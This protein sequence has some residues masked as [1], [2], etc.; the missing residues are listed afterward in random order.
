MT[1]DN[2][3][4]MA[5]A[6]RYTED[7]RQQIEDARRTYKPG[8]ISEKTGL[9]KQNDGTWAPPKVGATGGQKAPGTTAGKSRY[10]GIKRLSDLP[11]ED[12]LAF[13]K[14][15]DATTGE[16][17]QYRVVKAG[18]VMSVKAQSPEEARDVLRIVGNGTIALKDIKE[19]GKKPTDSGSTAAPEVK[20]ERGFH[21]SGVREI[22]LGNDMLLAFAPKEEGDMSGWSIY[23]GGEVLAGTDTWENSTPEEIE[24]DISKLG[25][26]LKENGVSNAENVMNA[27]KKELKTQT[28]GS[29]S[30][31]SPRPKSPAVKN[32]DVLHMTKSGATKRIQAAGGK[33]LGEKDGKVWFENSDGGLYNFTVTNG[34]VSS[35]NSMSAPH[36]DADKAEIEKIKSG[37]TGSTTATKAES[38]SGISQRTL[39]NTHSMTKEIVLPGYGR[40]MVWEPNNGNGDV[41]LIDSLTDKGRKATPE[42]AKTKPGEKAPGRYRTDGATE[43]AAPGCQDE[44]LYTPG[45]INGP[46]EKLERQLTGD[47]RIRVKK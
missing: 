46:R 3:M 7:G 40:V 4:N 8:E 30:K 21:N 27:V 34:K 37:I 10:E 26:A 41:F 23:S 6:D 29:T 45:S 13:R 14:R 1:L 25:K 22:K 18:K 19:V 11:P 17:N 31:P 43:D 44:Q 24:K 47:T 5:T 35:S 42:E 20:V 2:L 38:F 33:L 32:P 28:S 9:Q 39:S 12:R 36:S 16:G 15:H